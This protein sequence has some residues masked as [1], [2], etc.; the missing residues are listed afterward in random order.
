MPSLRWWI[1]VFACVTGLFVSAVGVSSFFW[2][3][4]LPLRNGFLYGLSILLAFLYSTRK[5][6]KYLPD[7]QPADNSTG[8]RDERAPVDHKT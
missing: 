6:P 2:V 1:P 8:Q 5:K 7:Q 3:S 4:P